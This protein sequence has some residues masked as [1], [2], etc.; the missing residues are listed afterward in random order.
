MA[1]HVADVAGPPLRTSAVVPV[2]DHV[3][4]APGAVRLVEQPELGMLLDDHRDALEALDPVAMIVAVIAPHGRRRIQRERVMS[5][6]KAGGLGPRQHAVGGVA[7]RKGVVGP[8][9]LV[10]RAGVGLG[11]GPHLLFVDRAP[12]RLFALI[13][14]GTIDH[15]AGVPGAVRATH[16][17]VGS[18]QPV[19]VEVASGARQPAAVVHAVGQKGHRQGTHVALADDGLSIGPGPGKRREQDRDQK[20]DD[21]HYDQDF[22]Q[23]EA[24]PA[25]SA[26]P[27]HVRPPVVRMLPPERAHRRWVPP[28]N[29]FKP[30]ADPCQDFLRLL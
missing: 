19:G 21:R 29:Q 22:D 10:G 14:V 24:R 15:P 9:G 11:H 17:A 12:L 7:V 2:G 6:Q 16:R 18:A 13:S 30:A 26:S 27:A 23:R 8:Q 5:G 3:L 25:C 20:R 4:I 28:L 1:V